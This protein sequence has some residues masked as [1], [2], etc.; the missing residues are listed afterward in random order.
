[1][2]RRHKKLPGRARGGLAWGLACF[3]LLQLALA[4]DMDRWQPELRDPEFG[5]KL[6]RL[7]ER[8]AEE[9]GR[10]LMV[11]IGS[12]RAGLGI[13]PEVFSN[14]RIKDAPI[15][16]NL[17]MTGAGPVTEL[18][19]LRRLLA[20]G[21]HPSSIIL[22]VLPPILHQDR[23]WSEWVWL[24]INRLGSQ[25]LPIIRDYADQVPTRY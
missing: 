1:M 13:C 8:L 9:P 14:Y 25:D 4:I 20:S 16:F 18:M 15:V 6:M 7:K 21:I 5:Y 11:V 22:E 3:A 2:R 10:P 23:A 17:A 24:D 19:C 12:S